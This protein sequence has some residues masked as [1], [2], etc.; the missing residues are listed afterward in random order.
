MIK[1][2]IIT[3]LIY[4]AAVIGYSY[5]GTLRADTAGMAESLLL[6]RLFPMAFNGASSVQFRLPFSLNGIS[7]SYTS[8]KGDYATNEK[9]GS[10]SSAGIFRADAYMKYKSS[11]LHGFAL[12]ENGDISNIKWNET[13][14]YKMVYPYLTADAIGGDMKYEHYDFGG[15]YADSKN[16]LE[17]GVYLSYEAGQYYR[18]VDPRPKNLTGT[19]TIKGGAGYRFHKNYIVSATAA[20]ERYTQ[21]NSVKFVSEMGEA[22][23]YHL[24]GMG[25]HYVRFAGNGLTAHYSGNAFSGTL[26]IIPGFGKGLIFSAEARHYGF[27]KILD[28]LNKLP[29]ATAKENSLRLEVGWRSKSETDIF[30]NPGSWRSAVAV[31]GTMEAVKRTGFENIFGD[32]ASSI[33]PLTGS[34]EKFHSN[35]HQYGIALLWQRSKGVSRSVSFEFKADYLR[36]H[37]NYVS[38]VRFHTLESVL[39]SL[40][41]AGNLPLPWKFNGK[42]ELVGSYY[43][44]LR[45]SLYIDSER[46]TDDDGATDSFIYEIRN[47]DRRYAEFGGK[48]SLLRQLSQRFAL[49]IKADVSFRS[50][51]TIDTNTFSNHILHWGISAALLF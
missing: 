8:E 29:L 5:A 6:S 34:K 30:H 28:D 19:L 31:K 51:H 25:T 39:G 49:N 24:T 44:P 33:Y 9:L 20:Y 3:T 1:L 38:P 22:K 42:L 15:G 17:W 40:I 26:N 50:Y 37:R 11:T 43:N 46:L 27:G 18:N 4:A 21:S 47:A 13:S 23:I 7:V 16:R 32:P 36:N 41:L 10:G 45:N 14:D 2:C 35:F 48:I 12:Y